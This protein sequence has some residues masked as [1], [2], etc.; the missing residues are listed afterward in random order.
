MWY[1]VNNEMI[2]VSWTELVEQ[3]S[4]VEVSGSSN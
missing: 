2:V 1:T 4:G 3:L